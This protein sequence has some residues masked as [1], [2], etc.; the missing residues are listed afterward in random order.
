MITLKNFRWWVAAMLASATAI[1][2][3]DRQ[4]LPVVITEMQDAISISDR[5]YSQLQSLFLLAYG[6]MYAGGGKIVDLLGSRIGYAVMIVWW[7][8]ANCLHGLVTGFPGLATARFLLGLGEG[9]SFPAAGKAVSE[10]FPPQERSF[11]FGIFNTG[12]SLGAVIAPPL[13]AAI[14]T[15][16]GWRCVF[17][18]TG[19]LGIF[20]AIAWLRLYETPANNKRV[21]PE[22]RE[23]VERSQADASATMPSQNAPKIGWWAL[24]RF[25]QT[26]GLLLARFCSE[27]AWYFFIFWLPKYLADVRGLNIKEIGYYAWI[28]YACAGAGSLVG[29]WFSSYLMRRHVS[30]DA[31]RKIALG[32]SAA[33]M[34]ASLGIANAPLAMAILFFGMAMFGHQAW[35]TM[36]QTL[37][38]DM[39]PSYI[40]GSALGLAGCV[41]TISAALF[42]LV[43]GSMVTQYGYT[44]VFVIAGLL[45]PLSFILLLLTI[46]RI[47]M[48]RV[49]SGERSVL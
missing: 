31:S 47:E 45:H 46:G 32:I 29:G 17:L 35:S 10:W 39:F 33:M 4:T 5:Q 16:F 24:F 14:V 1:N 44:P 42:Q 48:C 15:L 38:A 2:Y 34:P 6:A 36:L 40:V 9:G 12:S 13:A 3:L 21:S 37:G 19:S 28:P 30:L 8:L 18:V 11:A 26:W 23:Y 7:S 25:R 41:G 20:W 27:G 22:E 43:V 49:V